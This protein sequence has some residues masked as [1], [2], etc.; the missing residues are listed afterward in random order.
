[1]TVQ[2]SMLVLHRIQKTSFFLCP[3]CLTSSE[4]RLEGR[5]CAS[6]GGVSQYI[7]LPVQINSLLHI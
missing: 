7:S 1:M 2:V 5:S 6:H 3:L 4:P